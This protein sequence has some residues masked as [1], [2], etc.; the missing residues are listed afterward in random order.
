MRPDAH[1]GTPADFGLD[2]ED[3]LSMPGSAPA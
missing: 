2:D 3:L 1:K